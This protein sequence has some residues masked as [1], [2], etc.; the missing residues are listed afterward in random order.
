[1]S[2]NNLFFWPLFLLRGFNKFNIIVHQFGTLNFVKSFKSSQ[3]KEF[4]EIFVNQISASIPL[5]W[6]SMPARCYNN[7]EQ[8][9]IIKKSSE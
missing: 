6:F 4:F 9:I 5:R 2:F 1:M 8:I 7:L 3:K